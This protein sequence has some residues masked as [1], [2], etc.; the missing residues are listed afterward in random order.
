MLVAG[1]V[2]CITVLAG[3]AVLSAQGPPEHRAVLPL[4]AA[5]SA[6]G[7]PI[8]QGCVVAPAN[9]VAWYPLDEQVGATAVNDIA[10]LPSSTVN[11]FGNPMPSGQLGAPGGADP[12]AGQVAGALYFPGPYID[13]APHPDL[14]FGTGDFTIDAWI[15][16]VPIV[17]AQFLSLIVYK[18]DSNTGTGYALYTAGNQ[19]GGRYLVLVMN[20]ATY[21]SAPSITSVAW[22]HVAIR[23]DRT[24]SAGEF[25]V[26]GASAGSFTPVATS[27]TNTAPML[28]GASFLSGLLLP[29]VGRHEIAI[30]ELELFNRAL[31]TGE[32]QS[33]F[34]AGPAGKCKPPVDPVVDL[35]D[36]PASINNAVGSPAMTAYPPGVVAIFPTVYNASPRG[37]KHLQPKALAWLGPDVSLEIEADTGPDQ[38]P[39]VN[40]IPALDQPNKDLKDDGVTSL[41]ALP[42]VFCGATTLN[43]TISFAAVT[44]VPLYVNVWF[45]FT[46]DGD[47]DD[48]GRCAA[49]PTATALFSEWA[50][51]NEIISVGSGPLP[52]SITTAPFIAERFQASTPVWMRIT[53][54]EQPA[55]DPDGAG[56]LQPDGRGP[57][58]GLQ[59]GETEDYRLAP[60]NP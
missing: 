20:G 13:V 59:F 7:P 50:I 52:L 16:P 30:D 31:Q 10:P 23:V 18:T 12:V 19:S 1:M 3:Q 27:V 39:T 32:I 40:I 26:N 54:S 24:N 48:S 56:P 35:G 4:V 37:P 51:Q 21:T 34:A 15:K 55:V 38:D 29:Q 49:S 41:P 57:N 11:N 60:D 33:I 44:S 53:L 36:A 9:L 14:D 6:T 42:T 45:D 22:Y 46:H 47:W 17:D 58:G 8:P 28:I 2:L 43:Y 5:D 25:F